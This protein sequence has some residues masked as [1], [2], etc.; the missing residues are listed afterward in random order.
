MAFQNTLLRHIRVTLGLRH[1]W[2]RT[3]L[4]SHPL[5]FAP[6]RL[7]NRH[8]HKAGGG[9]VKAGES[10]HLQRRIIIW[11]VLDLADQF[12]VDNF[13]V[14]VQYH[15]R[16]GAQA[17]E[18]AVLDG[19]AV[20]LLEG[21]V[22]KGG[23]GFYVVQAFGAAEAGGG[24]GQVGGD[25]EDDGVVEATGFFVEFSGAGGADAG[26]DAGDDV[27]DF[28]LAGPVIEFHFFQAAAGQCERGCVVTG[29]G[30]FAVDFDGV[31][32]QGY[33]VRHGLLLADWFREFVLTLCSLVWMS[34]HPCG[35]WGYSFRSWRSEF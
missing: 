13:V 34:F 12:A 19:Y 1:P 5:P 4:E 17:G 10:K 18:G 8:H 24:E 3:V 14:L 29:L 26:V 2:L 28:A 15:D 20:V 6:T 9:S 32:V 31:A 7:G 30:E 33:V 25:D 16:T 27:Q 11:L 23:E 35:L 22:A 21:V